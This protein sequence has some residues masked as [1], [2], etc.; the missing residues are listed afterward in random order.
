LDLG[1]LY[2]EGELGPLFVVRLH[3][4]VATKASADE[5]ADAQTQP[6]AVRVQVRVGGKLAEGLKKLI[7]VLLRDARAVVV[8]ADL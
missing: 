6:V 1:D 8:H 2:P 7:L 3:Y 4:D 5:L